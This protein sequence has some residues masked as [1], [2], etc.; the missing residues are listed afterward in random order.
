MRVR[1]LGEDCSPSAT[2]K[3]PRPDR[4]VLPASRRVPVPRPQ[5]GVRH[6]A[7]RI[8]AGSSTS[9]ASASTCRRNRRSTSKTRCAS[10]PTRSASAAASSGP[11]WGRRQAARRRPSSSGCCCPT[12]PLRYQ[13]PAGVRLPAGD[14]G[15]HRLQHVDG[16]S[17]RLDADPMHKHARQQIY[18][19]RSQPYST[20]TGADGRLLRRAAN[21]DPPA[22]TGASRSGSFRGSRH[23]RRSARMRSAATSGCRSTTRIAGPGASTSCPIGRSPKKSRGDGAG[24][25]IHVKYIPGTFLPLA[26]RE[27]RLADRPH[28]Q[29]HKKSFSGVEGFSIQ[30]ASLQESMGRIV[31]RTTERLGTSDAAIIAARRTLLA[32]RRIAE[33]RRPPPDRAR[34]GS[35]IRALGL[36]PDPQGRAVAEGAAEALRAAPGKPFVSV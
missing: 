2:A 7:A 18:Q 4:R 36:D 33:R 17:L 35:A 3:A 12:P 11:T 14:R 31:D 27:Q 24:Q 28:A 34:T 8:T 16:A 15:R 32:R 25:G 19:G 23:L 10:T 26:N 13:T 30:D 1:L 20:W 29:K 22:T 5:R 21:G 6:S 9:T